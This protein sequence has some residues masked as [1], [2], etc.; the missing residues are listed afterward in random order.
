MKYLIMPILRFILFVFAFVPLPVMLFIHLLLALWYWKNPVKG[1]RDILN[2]PIYVKR[3][4]SLSYGT[5]IWR[6]QTPL[7]LLLDRKIFR[8]QAD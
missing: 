8:E 1:W 2:E 6:Y 4:F 3:E 5:E 7:D